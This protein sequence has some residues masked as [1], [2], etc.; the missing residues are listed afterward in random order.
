ME[1]E[2]ELPNGKRWFAD[3]SAAPL[4][5]ATGKVVGGVAVSVVITL[6]K[7]TEETLRASVAYLRALLEQNLVGIYVASGDRYLYVNQAACDILGYSCD[8]L[9][10]DIN[11]MDTVVEVDRPLVAENMRRRFSNEIPSLKYDFR[12]IRKDG[13]II[14]VEVHGARIQWQGRPALLGTALDITE[15]HA[16]E[17][18]LA[19]SHEE[20]RALAARLEQTREEERLRIAR[21]IHDELGQNLTAM[22]IDLSTLRKA[23]AASSTRK[24]MLTKFDAMRK[25]L[26]STL[27]T[28]RRICSELRPSLLKNLGLCAAIESHG[29]AFQA[30]SGIRCTFSLPAEPFKLNDKCAILLFRIFQEMLTN[31]ARHARASQVNI[32]L[33]S[34]NDHLVLK[35]R[36]NGRGIT[37][38]ALGRAKTL[39]I[40]GMRERA[41]EIGGELTIRRAPTGGTSAMVSVPIANTVPIVPAP[42]KSSRRAKLAEGATAEKALEQLRKLRR[43]CRQNRDR[44][45]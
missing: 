12:M 31:V 5:D 1:V 20:L 16:A 21:E 19:R 24:P 14:R 37:K 4:H 23:F 22:K 9:L 2:I 3:V 27:T 42:R 13:R 8:E 18:Q 17:E 26:A 33:R 10:K 32:S 15:R 40:V 7:Q 30:R 36:D 6:R 41:L 25:I 28:V 44:L 38:G 45:L 39:G 29:L 11:P 43:K 35:V 34:Q